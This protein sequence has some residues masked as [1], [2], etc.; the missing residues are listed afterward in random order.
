[1]KWQIG[2]SGFHYKHW[3]ERFYPQGLAMKNW[4]AYYTDFFDTVELNVTH[5]R[6]PQEK[7]LKEWYTKSPAGFAF[8]VKMYQ[9]I[10]HYKKLNDCTRMI[11]DFYAIVGEG[12]RDKA[13]CVL[14]QFP[15]NFHYNRDILTGSCKV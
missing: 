11:R 14:F 12:L 6:F 7:A 10:T 5:Y 13:A 8:A 4:F 15:P 3:R 9:G 1:M 2:C